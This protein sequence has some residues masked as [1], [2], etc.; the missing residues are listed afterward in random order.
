[1]V[2]VL[3]ASGLEPILLDCI[4]IVDCVP[5]TYCFGC[6][7]AVGCVSGTDSVEF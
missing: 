3:W 6:F 7:C 4:I 5:G 2:S 1:M